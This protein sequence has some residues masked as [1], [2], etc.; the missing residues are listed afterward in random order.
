MDKDCDIGNYVGHVAR[1][2]VSGFPTKQVSNQ[3]AQLQRLAG[4]LKCRI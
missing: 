1:K 2:P 4:K 3:P